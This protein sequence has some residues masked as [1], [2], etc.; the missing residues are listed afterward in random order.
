MTDAEVEA[1]FKSLATRKLAA[2]Q[3]EQA[4][5]RIWSFE[6]C[7]RLDDV[8]DALETASDRRAD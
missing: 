6:R 7:T 2:A 8:F 4:F 5:E 1:K 3:A